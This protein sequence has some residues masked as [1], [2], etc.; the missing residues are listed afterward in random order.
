MATASPHTIA[1]LRDGT[2]SVVIAEDDG[3]V[4]IAHLGDD[5]GNDA[6]DTY[7]LSRGVLGGGLDR[8]VF[9]WLIAEPSRSWMGH[10]GLQCRRGDSVVLPT[11]VRMHQCATD[12]TTCTIG[13]RDEL[14]GIEL[15][16]S[17]ALT[18]AG[19]VT[20]DTACLNGGA[21]ALSIDVLTV[22]VPIDPRCT[23]L[24]TL[25]GRHAMEAVE[26]RHQWHRNVVSLENRSGRTSHEQMNAVFAGTPGF[27][28]QSGRVTAVHCA[29]SGNSV[30]RCDA[31]TDGGPVIQV[32]ELLQP[33]EVRLSPGES[34]RM[35]TAVIAHSSRGI[36]EASHAFHRHIRALR[37]AVARPVI[38]NTWEAVYFRHDLDTLRRLASVAAEVGIERFVLDDGW[39]HGRR[40][41][42]KGLGDWWVDATVWPDGLTPLVDHVRALGMEFGLWF[43]PEMVNPDSDLF[44]IHPEWALNG[45]DDDPVLGRNQLVLDMANPD[46]RDYLFDHIDTMLST[47]DIAYVKWDHNRPLVGGASHHQ[48]LGTY[49]LFARLGEAHPDVQF[50]S[51]ASGGGRIDIGIARHVDRF[52][53]SDSIDA[54]DRL[55]IQRGISKLVPIEM[56]GS[57]IGSPTCHTTGRRHA[58]SFRTA[59][60]MFGWLGVEWNLLTLND[61]ER[62]GLT[63]GIEMYKQHRQ[64]LHSGNYVRIDHPDTTMHLHGVLATDASEAL[65][66]VSRVANGASLRS[67]PIRVSGLDADA[68]YEVRRIENGNP[69][70]ALHRALPGWVDT[71]VTMTGRRLESLGLTCPPLLPESTMLVHVRRVDR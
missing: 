48:T 53:T 46:V 12:S 69:R 65:I 62:T 39:F 13:L 27:S 6:I 21:D 67:A 24:L 19:T 64:L 7:L 40:D 23:E 41:D 31:L 16:V 70:W 57:H 71:P 60:A 20:I 49:E 61:K 42:T 26:H 54:L 32:G 18:D 44:R 50:E 1:H 3:A 68:L 2:I 36:N 14:H 43:E 5:I 25:G 17:I 58:L 9:P 56:M 34:Y 55:T 8:P 10:P 11:R 35:P 4:F 63:A 33:G 15:E 29:W 66:G 52:W 22:A 47:H 51:C 59:T 45:T 38:V 30:I 37:P 28:E